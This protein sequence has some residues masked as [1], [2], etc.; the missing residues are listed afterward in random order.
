[1]LKTTMP[2]RVG[3]TAELRMLDMASLVSGDTEIADGVL[4]DLLMVVMDG[5]SVLNPREQFAA[6]RRW[7]RGAYDLIERI[8]FVPGTSTPLLADAGAIPQKG[9]ITS[10]DLHL[11]EVDQIIAWFRYGDAPGPP[12]AAPDDRGGAAAAPP[13]DDLPE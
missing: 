9:Q 12:P 4:A 3:V 11:G 2:L 10:A 7:L 1:M 5:R 13:G 8:A 6:N